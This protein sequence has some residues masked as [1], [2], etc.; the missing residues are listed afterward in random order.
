MDLKSSPN[1]NIQRNR[2][3]RA[4]IQ[5]ARASSAAVFDS[6]VAV[7]DSTVARFDWT[8]VAAGH[9]SGL[10]YLELLHLVQ[11]Q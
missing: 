3:N 9:Y 7:P 2:E 5:S 4:E 6:T 1:Y 8:V 11:F 10:Q